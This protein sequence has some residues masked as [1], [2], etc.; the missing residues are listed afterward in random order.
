MNGKLQ[1]EPQKTRATGDCNG[2]SSLFFGE[3]L[4]VTRWSPGVAIAWLWEVKMVAAGIGYLGLLKREFQK[5]QREDK[6]G[7]TTTASHRR[8]HGKLTREG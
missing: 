6:T 3:S 2:V 4:G 7:K 5:L 1:G 8:F